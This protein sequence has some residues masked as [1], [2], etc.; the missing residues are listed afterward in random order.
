MRRVGGGG[1]GGGG[2]GCSEKR[3]CS[4]CKGRMGASVHLLRVL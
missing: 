1:G 2:G 3:E 4:A